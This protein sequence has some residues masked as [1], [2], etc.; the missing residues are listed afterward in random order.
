[1]LDAH[2]A[3]GGMFIAAVHDDLPGLATQTIWLDQA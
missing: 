1:V 2:R 3:K